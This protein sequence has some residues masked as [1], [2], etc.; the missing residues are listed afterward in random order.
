MKY[1]CYAHYDFDMHSSTHYCTTQKQGPSPLSSR[2]LTAAARAARKI[3]FMDLLRGCG[4]RLSKG[5]AVWGG[6]W[7]NGDKNTHILPLQRYSDA[8]LTLCSRHVG[9]INVMLAILTPCWRYIDVP[10]NL[11]IQRRQN[12]PCSRDGVKRLSS[13]PHRI[14]QTLQGGSVGV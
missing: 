12:K 3:K 5:W 8:M 4:V 7:G 2:V 14:S 10:T 11:Y 6:G 9:Y 1:L 13:S